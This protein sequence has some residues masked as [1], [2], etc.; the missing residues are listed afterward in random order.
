M[1]VVIEDTIPLE[2]DLTYKAYL[3]KI[4]EQQDGTTRHQ[5]KTPML[6]LKLDIT[7]AF[8]TIKWEPLFKLM[9]RVAFGQRWRNLL[10]LIWSTMTSRIMV[11]GK[12]GR[13][14]KHVRGLHQGD[15]LSLM[16]FI[17]AMDPLQ[18]ILDIAAI[19]GLL[20]PEGTD[21]IKMRTSLY[22]DDVVLFLRPISSD[23]T[24][25]QPL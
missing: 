21:P 20:I 11:N 12:P 16:L 25:L 17:I 15:P 4:L 22:A 6:L 2:A 3:V 18:K 8:D 13:P 24:N 14:I 5:S 7:K 1:N 23:V 19:E 10:S 9:E